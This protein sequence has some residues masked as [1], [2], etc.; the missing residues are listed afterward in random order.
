MGKCEKAGLTGSERKPHDA[1][2]KETNIL[3]SDGT[4]LDS[5]PSQVKN[6]CKK[7]ETNR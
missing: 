6:F 3:V 5:S 7:I 2:A 4:P 1:E